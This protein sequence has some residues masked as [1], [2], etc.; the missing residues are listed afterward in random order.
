MRPKRP[1]RN[2]SSSEDSARIA[3]VPRELRAVHLRRLEL[4]DVLGQ[5]VLVRLVDQ[6][7]EQHE[8]PDGDRVEGT[9]RQHED[10]HRL[11]VA[12]R[13]PP[14]GVGGQDRVEEA[15][16][17]PRVRPRAAGAA[18]P[19]LRVPRPVLQAHL[20]VPAAAGSERVG[21]SA[22]RNCARRRVRRRLSR[23]VGLRSR[24]ADRLLHL[25]LDAESHTASLTSWVKRR[26]RGVYGICTPTILSAPPSTLRTALCI[27]VSWMSV[28]MSSDREVSYIL[29]ASL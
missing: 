2:C 4:E 28:M 14:P 1:M 22:R 23:L 27:A 10:A 24:L 20:A 5:L 15:R 11:R 19:E 25:P 12:Q 18:R 29:S 21:R 17:E 9:E 13:L 26:Q 7:E 16:A 3:Q 8:H 6:A